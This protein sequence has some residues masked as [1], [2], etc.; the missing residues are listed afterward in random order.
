MLNCRVV[1]VIPGVSAG[2][3]LSKNCRI[4]PTCMAT[5]TLPQVA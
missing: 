3:Q 4:G 2:K 1:T 5:R